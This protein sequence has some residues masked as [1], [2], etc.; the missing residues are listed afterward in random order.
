MVTI[1]TLNLCDI[2]KEKKYKPFF[3]PVSRPVLQIS[4]QNGIVYILVLWK[5]HLLA[6]RVNY[7][8]SSVKKATDG[9]KKDND[10]FVFETW[11]FL[12]LIIDWN[13]KIKAK[14]PFLMDLLWRHIKHALKWWDWS[15]LRKKKSNFLGR[16]Q[17]G[18][19]TKKTFW[20][21]KST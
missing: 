18:Q 14:T 19:V 3:P 5:W 21:Y 6:K 4:L 9:N 16:P 11:L 10:R 12:F 2:A 15:Q 13:K 20:P 1:K 8:L 7:T 17:F